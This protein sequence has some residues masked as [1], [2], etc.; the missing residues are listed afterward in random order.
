MLLCVVGAV[1]L[2]VHIK[3]GE[4]TKLLKLPVIMILVYALG[5]GAGSLVQSLIVSPDEI[6][7]E[8]KYL[9]NNIEYKDTLTVSMM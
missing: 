4:I 3:K 7:K 1:T 5:V 6:N 2:A 8:S 9:E